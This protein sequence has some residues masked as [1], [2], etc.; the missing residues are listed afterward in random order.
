M[1]VFNNEDRIKDKESVKDQ[2]FRISGDI[3]TKSVVVL[4][5]KDV[6]EFT[7]EELKKISRFDDSE[8]EDGWLDESDGFKALSSYF[9]PK[10]KDDKLEDLKKEKRNE[11]L[12][13]KWQT[14]EE[15]KK[16]EY[17]EKNGNYNGWTDY[18]FD[19][20]LGKE[21]VEEE[22]KLKGYVEDVRVKLYNMSF[23]INKKRAIY[24]HTRFPKNKDLLEWAKVLGEYMETFLEYLKLVGVSNVDEDTLFDGYDD[25]LEEVYTRIVELFHKASQDKDA[26]KFEF[27]CKPYHVSK[28]PDC[29][30]ALLVSD[31][32]ENW[33]V[34]MSRICN[35]K[36]DD[37]RK[38][39]KLYYH[40]NSYKVDKYE[41]IKRD[42]VKYYQ[43]KKIKFANAYYCKLMNTIYPLD[44]GDS[45]DFY[46][47][48]KR[49]SES[50]FASL[51]L[52]TIIRHTGRYT[53]DA[54]MNCLV[55]Q[56]DKL[57]KGEVSKANKIEINVFFLAEAKVLSNYYE[58][59]GDKEGKAK[60]EKF[61]K[62][63]VK[64]YFDYYKDKDKLSA[65]DHKESYD[66]LTG[67]ST[68]DLLAYMKDNITYMLPYYDRDLGSRNTFDSMESLKEYIKEYLVNHSIEESAK[69][70]R[71]IYDDNSFK[72]FAKLEGIV[73]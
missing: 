72:C 16:D 30:F 66:D 7:E 50:Y 41:D 11:L 48:G 14:T 2:L 40:D 31:M 71:A 26:I 13:A 22:I 4:Y 18:Y 21:F 57:K 73:I 19:E 3:F 58:L 6:T 65:T 8:L 67:S 33:D 24:A 52:Q 56:I 43:E 61:E 64:F 27:N 69:R 25:E 55:E 60:A 10:R 29:D 53:F 39:L 45:L 15:K 44:E 70:M 51:V 23:V 36:E 38:L 62:S 35:D 37:F 5:G 34:G 42:L 28:N 54:K 47:C 12:E 32:L 68:W 49:Y 63:L 1:D 20:L 59:Q 17:H 9:E 46:W